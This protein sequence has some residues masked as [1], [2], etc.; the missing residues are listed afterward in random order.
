MQDSDQCLL[1]YGTHQTRVQILDMALDQISWP[2]C[3][4]SGSTVIRQSE[5]PRR[6]KVGSPTRKTNRGSKKRN[7]GAG[8]R[9]FGNSKATSDGEA[10]TAKNVYLS[11]R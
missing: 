5:T 1:F 9:S 8:T 11:F 3:T 7:F 2:A 4:L 6:H 10:K